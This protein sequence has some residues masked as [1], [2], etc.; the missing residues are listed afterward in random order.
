MIVN[1]KMKEGKR[2]VK[3]LLYL[4]LSYINFIIENVLLCP[5]VHIEIVLDF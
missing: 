4:N 5:D 2:D 1:A 3:L